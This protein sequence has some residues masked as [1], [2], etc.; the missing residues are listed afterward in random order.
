MAAIAVKPAGIVTPSGN[1]AA[2]PQ[3][4]I[5]ARPP[6]LIHLDEAL[7]VLQAHEDAWV[8]TGIDE[9]IALLAEIR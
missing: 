8:A 5:A 1:G 3:P 7:A 6:G 2:A 9:R 4:G